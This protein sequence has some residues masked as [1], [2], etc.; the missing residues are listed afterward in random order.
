MQ[1]HIIAN[2]LVS[3]VAGLTNGKKGYEKSANV[4]VEILKAAASRQS[5]LEDLMRMDED[6]FQEIVKA[7]KLPRVTPEHVE[8]RAKRLAEAAKKAIEVPWKIAA[9]ASSILDDALT[10]TKYG[11]K[12]AITDSGC[13]GEF[14]RSAAFGVIQ[15]IR[16][17]LLSIQDNDYV[18]EQIMKIHFFTEDIEERYSAINN[19]IESYLSRQRSK[20]A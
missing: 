18:A 12:S 9:V 10:L 15:N 11:L 1:N 5:D 6:A 3:M 14:A 8:I 17:N 19:E 7:W 4:V 2:S 13:A 16:I 20:N